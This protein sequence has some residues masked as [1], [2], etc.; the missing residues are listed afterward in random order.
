MSTMVRAS[1]SQLLEASALRAA[2]ATAS[3][4]ACLTFFSC[5]KRIILQTADASQTKNDNQLN[6]AAAL[7]ELH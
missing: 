3:A 4:S 5:H 2:V 1:S 6:A 7:A